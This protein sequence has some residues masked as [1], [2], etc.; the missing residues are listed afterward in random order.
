[1]VLRPAEA[2]GVNTGGQQHIILIR[3]VAEAIGR[4]AAFLLF[5][6]LARHLGAEA[7]GVQMQTAAVAGVL[8]PVAT[9]GLGFGVVRTTAGAVDRLHVSARYT[10][11]LS[12]ILVTSLLLAAA[13]ALAAPVLNALFFK[14]PWA[15]P[16]IRWAA[17]LVPLGALESVVIDF[18]RARL[19]ILAQSLFQIAQAVLLVSAVVIVLGAGGQLL[20]VVWASMGVKA[21][22]VLAMVA[23]FVAVGEVTP[24]RTGL[25]RREVVGLVRF[26]LPIVVM[27]LSTW[28]MSIGDRLIIGWYLD[29]RQVGIYSAAY[30]L[31]TLIAYVATPLWGPLYPLM[32]AAAR[33]NRRD[34]LTGI[35]RR[36]MSLFLIIGVPAVCGLSLLSPAVLRLLGTAEFAIHPLVFALIAMG[37]LSDQVATSAHYLVYLHDEPKFLRNVTMLAG[38]A[39]LVLNLLLVPYL[40]I[41]GAAVA[42]LA[43]YL[44]LDVLLYRRVSRYGYGLWELYDRGVIARVVFSAAVMSVVVALA[45]LSSGAAALV[46]AAL[47]GAA[48]YGSVLVVVMG[49]TNLRRLAEGV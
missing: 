38:L 12:I 17:L 30:S 29:V 46:A 4:G 28:I 27:G 36:Y 45:P 31:A 26:G 25:S 49:W 44:L 11:T 3:F 39:N 40:H 32:A 13:V 24:S 1:M 16:V 9:L 7:Y 18:Y 35:C 48:A 5:P 10:T 21:M 34:V 22:A 20:H 47:L 14:A 19:R 43:A 23:Y 33:E 42:T 15:T 37:L 6:L 2:S 8:V 41:L